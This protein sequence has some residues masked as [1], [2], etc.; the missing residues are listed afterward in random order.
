MT[1]VGGHLSGARIAIAGGGIAGLT[2]ATAFAQRGAEV[3]VYERAPALREVG[4]GLQ[5]TPNGA[6]PLEAMGLRDAL[7]REGLRARAVA[8]MDAV[9]GRPVARFDLTGFDQPPYRF[10]HR[11]T[12]LDL[13]ADAAR[14]AGAA[15]H[16]GAAAVVTTGGAVSCGGRYGEPFDLVVGADGL[17]SA[18]RGLLNGAHDPFFTGQVAWRALID[19]AEAEPVARIWMAPGRHLVSY[20]LPG[21]KLNI[22]AVQ[23][24]K[25]WAAEGWHHADSPSNLR[26]AFAGLSG[27]LTGLLA[28]VDE[29]ALWGLFRH[30]VARHWAAEKLALIGD[31][32]HPTLPFLAQGANLAIEDAWLLAALCDAQPLAQAL[33][34]YQALRRPRVV[35]AITAANRNARNYHLS[36]PARRVAHLG[37]RG[38]SRA[39]PGAFLG[40]MD[41]LYGHDVT[42]VTL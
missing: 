23:A 4:A 33:P 40:R 5:I 20:P 42:Q 31:A 27:R 14:A 35:R 30:E 37:L 32:A 36:G 22:V 18:A 34:R 26:A 21:G 28:E 10:F 25:A 39:L 17:H 15:I 24:R 16:L 38:M 2:A 9:S 41:W 7:D 3:H 19:R 1:R 8:P 29:V 11:A 13:L 6:R 12:L